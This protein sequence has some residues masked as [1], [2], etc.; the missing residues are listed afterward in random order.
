M[1]YMLKF[2]YFGDM[3]GGGN[4]PTHR[5]D[6]FLETKKAK[7]K[8]IL[9]I[10]K[11][12][13]VNALL[14]GGDFLHK[15]NISDECLS[16]E[17]INWSQVNLN[18]LAFDVMIGNKSIN[19]LGQ[20][21]KNS[22]PMIGTIGNHDLIGGELESFEKT[23]LNVLVQSG[24]MTL[25]TKEEPIIF[26]DEEEGFSLAISA[27]PYTHNIDGDDKSAY[28]VDEKKGD[29]HIHLTHG[30]LMDKSYG[31]KFKH[32]TVQEIAYLTKADLTINAHDHVG[33]KEIELDEKKFINSGSPVRLSAE[34]KEIAR[35]PKVLLVTIDKANGIQL[36]EIY[37][38]AKPG[39][40]VL[41]REHIE[42]KEEKNKYVEEVKSLINKAN[43][44]KGVDITEIISNLGIAE[45][46]ESHII[47]EVVESVIDSMSKLMTPFNPKGEYIIERLELENF[48]SHKHSVFE[49]TEG[50]NI[51]S[52]ES[53]QGKSAV[54]RAIREL[55]ECYMKNPR[56]AIFFG[57]SYFKVTA[58][59][60]SGYI[61][62]RV[63]ERKNTGKNGYEIFDPTTGTSSYYNT[64]GL[65]IVQEI[66]GFN[67]IKLTEKNKIN[68]N[69]S[70]QGDG[71]FMLKNM[72]A[73]DRAKLIGVMYGT[74]YADA[75]LKE[76]NSQSKKI[77]ADIN[78]Y[79]KDVTNLTT[80]ADA[81]L[82]LEPFKECLNEAEALYQEAVEL[83]D[84]IDKA[85]ELLE[86]RNNIKRESSELKKV[87]DE[88][89]K[90]EK[91]Y[92]QL[93]KEIKEDTENISKIEKNIVDLNSIVKDG[94]QAR[95][96]VTN[97]NS[98][99]EA[100]ELF[101]EINKM[102]EQIS[103]ETDILKNA[104]NLEGQLYS[105]SI[106]IDNLSE[107]TNALKDFDE[108]YNL[109]IEIKSLEQEISKITEKVDKS[110]VMIKEKDNL[111]I[112]IENSK[113]ILKEFGNLNE[114]TPLLSEIEILE[115]EIS[116]SESLIKEMNDI[117]K[118]IKLAKEEERRH[119]EQTLIHLEN[120]QK[121]LESMGEC[122]VCHGH[123][124]NAVIN[125]LVNELSKNLK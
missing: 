44:K 105:M 53:R 7:I 19:D 42:N 81:Y 104:K 97:L 124:T 47:K 56:K 113:L 115:D 49:F 35:M 22:I 12:N 23:S 14:Q 120:Y 85:T 61:V 98:L 111:I 41:S 93:L 72:S 66:L 71:W 102:N 34:K 78:R 20:I 65:D 79:E 40:E 17:M 4:I 95:Y 73:P 51:L 29:F 58:Y 67:K 92:N 118:D 25:A 107:I 11:D 64:K 15:G 114:A 121:E 24:F 94:K 33:Y 122:P 52:G 54:L 68:V 96:V 110:K 123:I 89:E 99:Q 31:K 32:T 82:Y 60:S 77:I 75:I 116:K 10:A 9:K 112:Q 55:Y 119:R 36:E 69:F 70:V 13:K 46:I 30:M 3:H 50:L 39:N 117:D 87:I 106:E 2:L 101:N 84:K 88:I 37:L 16:K 62:T 8:E 45:G 21:L 74:H 100:K 57:E 26:K 103:K 76:L 1:V 109:L 59:L 5:T 125:N 91:E 83:N 86:D 38:T 48:Q 108:A 90:N 63:V 27:S 43:I 6:D 28:I 80:E 18:N